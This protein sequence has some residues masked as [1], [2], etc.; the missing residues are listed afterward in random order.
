MF[1]LYLFKCSFKH[2][3]QLPTIGEEARRLDPKAFDGIL[4]WMGKPLKYKHLQ[5]PIATELQFTNLAIGIFC[6]CF[7]YN[8][9]TLLSC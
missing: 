5:L 2:F 6:L 4:R 9:N 7:L 8:N 1:I 3:S